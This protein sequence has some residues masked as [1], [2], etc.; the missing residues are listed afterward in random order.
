MLLL[1]ETKKKIIVWSVASLILPIVI[2]PLHFFSPMTLSNI[3]LMLGIIYLGVAGLVFVYRAG[4]FDLFNFQFVNWLNS[5]RR[6]APAG[7][8]RTANDSH[9]RKMDWRKHHHF[10]YW[11]FVIE[12]SLLLVASLVLALVQVYA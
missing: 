8:D 6:N 12:G 5:W 4:T 3:F 9:L 7:R 2:L 1:P 10:P 11:A